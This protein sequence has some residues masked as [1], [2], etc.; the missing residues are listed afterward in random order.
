MDGRLVLRIMFDKEKHILTFRI[1]STLP[2]L[3]FSYYDS[4]GSVPLTDPSTPFSACR[5]APSV[6]ALSGSRIG[7]GST[8]PRCCRGRSATTVACCGLQGISGPWLNN[9]DR[10]CS[11]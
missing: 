4:F 2:E 10:Q 11:T 6:L 9:S 7:R 3:D 1:D 8:S 5:T